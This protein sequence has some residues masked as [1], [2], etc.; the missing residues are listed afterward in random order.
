LSWAKGGNIVRLIGNIIWFLTGG[1]VLGLAWCLLGLLFF[2]TVVL[3]P[4][5]KACFEIGKL[6]FAPFG[7]DIVSA[8]DIAKVRSHNKA[9]QTGV[10]L[11]GSSMPMGIVR[12][13]GNLIWL[14]FGIVL[15]IGHLLHGI[16]LMIFLIT[17]PFGLQEFKIAGMSLVPVGKRVVSKE[18]ATEL[19]SA[20]ARQ[21]LGFA[22]G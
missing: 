9:A 3:A 10:D 21:Q 14:P 18:F 17:I 6:C 4:W 20:L 13:I 15:M 1:I 16:I 11:S 5:G 2:V 12:L 19:R 7:K 22:G 8:S